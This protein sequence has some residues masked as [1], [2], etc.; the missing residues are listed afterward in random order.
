MKEYIK[1]LVVVLVALV[2]YDL[3]V[4]KFVLKSSGYEETL[5]EI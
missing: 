1:N 2:V 4:K 3:L 5:E